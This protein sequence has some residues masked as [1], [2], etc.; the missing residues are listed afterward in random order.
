MKNLVCTSAQEIV[1]F[2]PVLM[3]F[4]YI[5]SLYSEIVGLTKICWKKIKLGNKKCPKQNQRFGS[6]LIKEAIKKV[7][8]K[9][10][11]R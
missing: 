1:V 3:F 9:N 11:V 7:F 6:F 5:F 10:L 4:N 8:R 2:L